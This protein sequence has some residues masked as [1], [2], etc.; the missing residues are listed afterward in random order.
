[1]VLAGQPAFG[2]QIILNP[3]NLAEWTTLTGTHLRD[4]AFSSNGPI[5]FFS[6]QTIRDTLWPTQTST[7]TRCTTIARTSLATWF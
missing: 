3:G 7:A 5:N 2:I 4:V 6:V 1:M